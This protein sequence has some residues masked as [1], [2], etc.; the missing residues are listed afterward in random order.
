VSDGGVRRLWHRLR[1]AVR[2]SAGS[3]DWLERE[4]FDSADA[5]RLRGELEE[6]AAVS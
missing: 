5:R 2:N 6:A 4:A 3:L 1:R